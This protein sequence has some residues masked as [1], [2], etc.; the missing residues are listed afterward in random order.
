MKRISNHKMMH[1]AAAAGVALVVG[2]LSFLGA[3]QLTGN[4]HVVLPG[5][6]YR[7]GQLTPKQLHKYNKRYEIRTII[8]LRGENKGADWYAAEV[9]EARQLGIAHVDFRMSAR[10]GLTIW[11][12]QKLV[13][14]LK[15]AQKPLLIH[16][17][18]GADRAGLVSALYLAALK[19]LDEETA[20][21][22]ISLWYGHISLP[23]TTAYPI[24]LSW[25]AMEPWLGFMD[26]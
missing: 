22:Q 2:I 16:C 13:N 12:A 21:S 10:H 17:K 14:I 3:I 1:I 15:Q 23:G 9:A 24:D 6:L 18:A 7:S 4:F 11:Q 25:E 8:N 5:E 20:E 19:G 26:S